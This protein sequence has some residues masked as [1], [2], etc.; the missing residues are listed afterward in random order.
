LPSSCPRPTFAGESHD[1][2][3]ADVRAEILDRAIV[4]LDYIDGE[5][6]A[7]CGCPHL[8]DGEGVASNERRPMFSPSHA[9]PISGA[10]KLSNCIDPR[11]IPSSWSDARLLGS[12]PRRLCEVPQRCTRCRSEKKA[13]SKPRIISSLLHHHHLLVFHGGL[14][15]SSSPRDRLRRAARGGAPARHAARWKRD[16]LRSDQAM[17]ELATLSKGHPV[18]STLLHGSHVHAPAR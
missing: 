1:R 3:S 6:L 17:T 10:R 18:T 16:S 11:Q 9:E 12:P 15:G 13:V 4:Y 2:V 14:Y 5:Q 8:L 7:I